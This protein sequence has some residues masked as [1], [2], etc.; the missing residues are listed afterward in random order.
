MTPVQAMQDSLTI[1]ITSAAA[2]KIKKEKAI[3][4]VKKEKKV[5]E[6]T[7]VT[8]TASRDDKLAALRALFPKKS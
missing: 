1:A 5:K 7:T 6:V 3:G 2:T 4:G 8:P